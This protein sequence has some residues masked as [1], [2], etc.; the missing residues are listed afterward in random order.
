MEEWGVQ[1]TQR[2][3][4]FKKQTKYKLMEMELLGKD[5]NEV[6][7]MCHSNLREGVVAKVALQT[8]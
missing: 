8:I 1:N 4:N 2:V 7:R 5:L 3:F 6:K